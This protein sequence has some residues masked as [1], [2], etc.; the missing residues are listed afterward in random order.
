[1]KVF[2][3]FRPEMFFVFMVFLVSV[4]CGSMPTQSAQIPYTGEQNQTVTATISS[5]E[6]LPEATELPKPT[7]T[8][9]PTLAPTAI[10]VGINRAE[11]YKMSDMVTNSTWN[12]QV[13]EMH[14]GDEA[15]AILG[16]TPGI[17]RLIPEGYDYHIV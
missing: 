3:K 16:S 1:M 5:P 2:K 6:S 10:P 9:M 12:V 8:M 14:R 13:L 15:W 4:S 17:V 7:A 11:P